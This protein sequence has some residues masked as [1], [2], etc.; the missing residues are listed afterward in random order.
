M[1]AVTVA[2]VARTIIMAALAV[3]SS[4][5]RVLTKNSSSPFLLCFGSS[6][7]Q[8]LGVSAF[9]V[10]TTATRGAYSTTSRTRQSVASRILLPRRI[11]ISTE[12]SS[13]RQSSL[14]FLGNQQQRPKLPLFATD[15]AR[16]SY[17][18]DEDQNVEGKADKYV[19]S[20]VSHEAEEPPAAAAVSTS[21]AIESFSATPNDRYDSLLS[22]VGLPDSFRQ[23]VRDKLPPKR[24]VSP[25]D[26]FCNRELKL[27]G[28]RAIGFDMDYTLAQYQQPAFDQLAF[29]GAKAKLVRNFGYPDAV[30]DLT[31]NHTQWT[32]EARRMVER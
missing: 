29:D 4:S 17:E 7:R 10:G 13:P 26:I 2:S 20:V 14:L 30:L 27:S 5:W 22:D 19:P 9:T 11:S 18:V 6:L 24:M 15:G 32:R 3:S 8:S 16:R 28:I 23:F 31:Y 1:T 21:K 25:N 12:R